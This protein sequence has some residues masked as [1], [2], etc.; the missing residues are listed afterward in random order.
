MR[1]NTKNNDNKQRGFIGQRASNDSG[2]IEN[3][4]FH[5]LRR[6]VFSSLRDETNVIVDYYLISCRLSTDPEIYCCDIAG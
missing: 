6:Y 3:M 5:G 2:V 4:D 1:P